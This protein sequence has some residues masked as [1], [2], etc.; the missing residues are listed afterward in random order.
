M[1]CK[2]SKDIEQTM[3]ALS[4]IFSLLE[5][6][7]DANIENKLESEKKINLLLLNKKKLSSVE[8]DALYYVMSKRQAESSIKCSAD[9]SEAQTEKTQPYGQAELINK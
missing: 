5:K 6:I 7:K 4:E 8:K 1:G 2:S 9:W 3:D